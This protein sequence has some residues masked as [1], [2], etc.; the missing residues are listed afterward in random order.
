[1][2]L[3]A[4]V[5]VDEAYFEFW[6]RTSL[7]LIHR[8]PNLLVTRSFSKAFALAGLGTTHAQLLQHL[9]D[10]LPFNFH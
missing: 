3:S 8:Y 9:A 6:G 1:M 4:L 5:I 2:A 10:C 7:A